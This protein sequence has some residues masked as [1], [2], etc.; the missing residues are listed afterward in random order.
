M[1]PT[2][3]FATEAPSLEV[4]DNDGHHR[5][6]KL[7]AEHP[8]VEVQLSIERAL[9]VLGALEAVSLS[10]KRDIRH[11]NLIVAQCL[12]HQFSLVGPYHKVVK[13]LE[14][15]D[16]GGDFVGEMDW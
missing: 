11:R 7:K 2:D 4:L 16:W 15:D 6:G 8:G 10:L 9:D 3:Y 14:E 1:R 12:D 13:T 5:V